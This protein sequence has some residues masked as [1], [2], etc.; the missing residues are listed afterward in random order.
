MNTFSKRAR[1]APARGFLLIEVLVATTLLAVGVT[2]ALD[3][4]FRCLEATKETRMYTKAVFLAQKQMS[5][6]ETEISFND[7]FDVPTSGDFD[8]E[9]NY[10]WQ[11]RVEEDEDFWTRRI[12]VS[13]IWARNPDD[14]Y[15]DERY[16]VYRVVTEV[17]MPRY[18]EDYEK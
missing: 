16:T 1:K 9:P 11:V 7:D 13:V 17:P 3:A 15:D 10:R 18:P 8:D 6:M 2:A 5:E 12:A 4:I 14:I